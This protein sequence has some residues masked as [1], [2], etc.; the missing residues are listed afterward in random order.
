MALL[1]RARANKSLEVTA[2]STAN[3]VD[4]SQ[5]FAL[6]IAADIKQ[7]L[8]L[9]SQEDWDTPDELVLDGAV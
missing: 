5:M 6:Q 3:T 9:S 4:K 1:G 2:A 8:I 7:A